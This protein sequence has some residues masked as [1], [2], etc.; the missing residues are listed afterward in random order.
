[1]KVSKNEVLRN[2]KSGK[3]KEIRDRL[4]RRSIEM[5]AEKFD[6][7]QDMVYKVIRGDYFNLELLQ[8]VLTQAEK[9]GET[10]AEV[11]NRLNKL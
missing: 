8:E 4:P 10:L 11:N 6:V 7:T 5:I 1:M 9:F 3:G 2:L